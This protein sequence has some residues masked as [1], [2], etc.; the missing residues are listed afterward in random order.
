MCSWAAAR[1]RLPPGDKTEEAVEHHAAVPEIEDP[2]KLL[3]KRPGGGGQ[4]GA[5][6]PGG[7][8]TPPNTGKEGTRRERL[9][10]A[11]WELALPVAE[12]RAL[13]RKDISSN[14]NKVYYHEKSIVH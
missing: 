8:K 13:Q 4:E 7:S 10:E 11:D 9:A 3:A 5:V 12:T 6:P 1:E 2:P 14:F